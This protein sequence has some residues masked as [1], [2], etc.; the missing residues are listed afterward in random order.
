MSLL[1]AGVIR[2]GPSAKL[3]CHLKKFRWT[4]KIEHELLGEHAIRK[5]RWDGTVNGRFL[6]TPHASK[7]RRQLEGI[8][9]PV[10]NEVDGTFALKLKT[11]RSH[12]ASTCNKIS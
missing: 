6:P 7:A 5:E 3:H 10:G 2:K 4:K 11:S 12:P 9:Y 8:L 1:E